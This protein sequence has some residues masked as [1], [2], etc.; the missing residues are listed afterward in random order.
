M[1]DMRN[2][3]QGLDRTE[4]KTRVVRWLWVAL[5]STTLINIALIALLC[6]R[7]ETLEEATRGTGL[8]LT[9]KLVEP[10]GIDS[11]KPMAAAYQHERSH[12]GELY[13]VFFVK[14]MRFQYPPSALLLMKLVPLPLTVP[15]RAKLAVPSFLAV[16]ITILCSAMIL[17]RL[18]A[19]RGRTMRGWTAYVLTTL[20][21]V[22][23]LGA[24][25]Y[26]LIK[27][28]N[29]GQVQVYLGALLAAALLAHIFDRKI[30]S[31]V[32]LGLCCLVKPQYLVVMVWALLRRQGSLL[33]GCFAAVSIGLA[34]SIA[35]FGFASHVQYLTVLRELSRHGESFGPNQSVNGLMHRLL[36]NGEA[37]AWL[38][39]TLPPYHP[40]VYYATLLSS[41]LFLSLA[42]FAPT[43]NAC[44]G[45]TLD[46]AIALCA[47]TIASPIA[48]EHHYGAFFP[49][50][51][52]AVPTLIRGQMRPWTLLISY[53]L[54]S[55]ELLRPTLLFVGGW[56]SI[57]GA[58]IFLGALLLFGTLLV[59]RARGSAPH[60]AQRVRVD[61]S[62]GS[63]ARF[64]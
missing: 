8:S 24:T 61:R 51:A 13:W 48:W 3:E 4:C 29:L 50:F 19:V 46:L 64:T 31:G 42:L 35:E 23:A 39:T 28:H 55:C 38:S 18:T 21:L 44:R 49:I 63:R 34:F 53:L 15:L 7:G 1:S 58:H 30:L 25:Y 54:M 45:R 9:P 11:W 52:L 2:L 47:A 41:I 12:P 43:A 57:P 17:L 33:V 59:C 56:R 5:A 27:G 36:S 6:L 62:I 22:C 10:T 32:F 37:V 20:V 60:V 40:V 16:A 14:R 26:P